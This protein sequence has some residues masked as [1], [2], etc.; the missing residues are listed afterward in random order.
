MHLNEMWIIHYQESAKPFNWI[1]LTCLAAIN[2][3]GGVLQAPIQVQSY[4]IFKVSTFKSPIPFISAIVRG[5]I[6]Q[7]HGN[8]HIRQ[9]CLPGSVVFQEIQ[10]Q[11]MKKDLHVTAQSSTIWNTSHGFE[12]WGFISLIVSIFHKSMDI[13]F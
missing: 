5:N 6:Y 10:T 8:Q 12:E 3:M 13:I 11:Q 4:Y 9:T 1:C 2:M 7:T